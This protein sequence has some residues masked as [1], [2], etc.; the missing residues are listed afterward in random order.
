MQSPMLGTSKEKQEVNFLK[1]LERVATL[2]GGCI[3]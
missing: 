1:I 3:P 2:F